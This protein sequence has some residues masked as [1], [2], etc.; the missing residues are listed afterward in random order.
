MTGIYANNQLLNI[1]SSVTG[2][3]YSSSNTNVLTVDSEGNVQAISFGT[4]VVTVGNSGLKAFATFVVESAT[5]PLP[6]QNVTSEVNISPSGFQLNR[7]TGFYVQTVTLTNSLAIP[8]T[9][10]LYLVI[11][12]L[13]NGV[14][15][16]TA[17]AGLTQTAQPT[18]SSYVKLQ[19]AGGL[20]LQPGASISLTL[21]F[22]NPA[23]VRISYNPEIYR[24]LGT[25]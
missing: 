10:P 14:R 22:L 17:G 23:R 3:T 16:A 12:G 25:P 4:A 21:Q 6:P 24:T 11:A 5:S 7:N 20:T 15:L 18:G 1:T 2:T 9:G 13:P 8:V 19:L